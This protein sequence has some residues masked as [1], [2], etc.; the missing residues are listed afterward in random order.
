MKPCGFKT[1][2]HT[3]NQ[4][5]FAMLKEKSVFDETLALLTDK[6]Q[7]EEK[8]DKTFEWAIYQLRYIFNQN[9]EAWDEILKRFNGDIKYLLICEASPWSLTNPKY[10]YLQPKGQLFNTIWKVFFNGQPQ[11]H[12]MIAWQRKAFC[13]LTHF[14]TVW[15][16]KQSSYV[17]GR[18]KHNWLCILRC[19]PT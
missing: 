1:K 6:L 15:F 12:R 13:L 9:E 14:H 5:N 10:F 11:K 8:D 4:I 2:S 3:L 7:K 18:N 19:Y 16:T 17:Q